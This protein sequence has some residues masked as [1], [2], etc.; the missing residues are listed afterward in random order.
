M[1]TCCT[2]VRRL[3]LPLSPPLS[4]PLPAPKDK[5][6]DRGSADFICRNPSTKY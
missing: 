1:S 4:L 2:S 6:D 5:K 3:G